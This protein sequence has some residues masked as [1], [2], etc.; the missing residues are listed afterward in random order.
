MELY[1]SIIGLIIL[2]VALTNYFSFSISSF[3]NRTREITL[4]QCLGGKS[5]NIFGLL[6]IEQFIILTFSCI[7]T[8]ALSESLLPAF[9]NSLS[10]DIRRELEIDIPFLLAS[11]LKYTVLI[12]GASFLLCYVSVTR[13][14]RHIHRKGL[15]GRAGRGKHLL[16]N[17]SL[18]SQFFFSFLFLFGI[19]GIYMQM[20]SY[21]SSTTPLLTDDEK[22][23]LIIIPTYSYDNKLNKELTEVCD[24]FRAKSWCE[25]LSLFCFNTMNLSLIHI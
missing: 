17:I 16:R 11:E 2:I 8:L 15:S 23:N 6:F 18:G 5:N 19:A 3:V 1:I 12:L 25:S 9:I 24:Y 21:S 13:I 20:Q 7:L 10:Y 4:R 14:I 22:E